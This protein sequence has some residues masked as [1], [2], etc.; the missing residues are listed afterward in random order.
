VSWESTLGSRRDALMSWFSRVPR[1]WYVWILALAA[2][3]AQGCNSGCDAVQTLACI[4]GDG[5]CQA[6]EGGCGFG[7]PTPS[8]EGLCSSHGGPGPDARYLGMCPSDGGV[9]DGGMS[10]DAGLR[11]PNAFP[12]VGAWM[13][14]QEA[15]CGT[16][17]PVL[18]DGGIAAVGI[19]LFSGVGNAAACAVNNGQDAGI[20][21]GFALNLVLGT[22]QF[23]AANLDED[24]GPLTQVLAPGVYTLINEEVSDQNLCARA[25]GYDAVLTEFEFMSGNATPLFNGVGTVTIDQFCNGMLYGTLNVWLGSVDGT[26]DVDGGPLTGTFSASFCP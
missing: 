20:E 9:P 11:G 14:P 16:T 24:A 22:P 12:I 3:G 26:S 4:C 2:A 15:A 8:C 23:V 6:G 17:S 19:Q 7:T 18:A 10:F 1:V 5:T 21:T 25:P 13:S